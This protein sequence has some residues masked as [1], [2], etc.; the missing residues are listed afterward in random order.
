MKTA[1]KRHTGGKPSFLTPR[2]LRFAVLVGGGAS[3]ADAYRLA[4]DRQGLSAQ[5]SAHRGFKISKQPAVAAKIA[6][7]VGRSE[8][9]TLLTLN[10]R[11]AILAKH[12]QHTPKTSADRQASVRAIDVYSKI[13]GD[14]L[15]ENVNVK[16][17]VEVSAPGGGPVEIV[18]AL[19]T[20]DKI[21]RFRAARAG[22]TA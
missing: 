19:T 12:A 2:G 21:A 11:L 7:L 14:G 4:F 15:G 3:Q 1:K 18:A 8:V 10:D 13:A 16:A 22:R 9:K 5:D 20:A 6:E 17:A